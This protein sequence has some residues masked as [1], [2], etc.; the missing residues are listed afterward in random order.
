MSR[1]NGYPSGIVWILAILLA[2]AM[3][4]HW[5]AGGLAIILLGGIAVGLAAVLEVA[6]LRRTPD[7]VEGIAATHSTSRW[8]RLLS[9]L[10]AHEL[11]IF[12][13]LGPLF[14]FPRRAFVLLFVLIPLVWLARWRVR[15]RLT[16]RTPLDVPII[17]L[18]GM[19]AVSVL[20]SADLERSFP[21]L[22]GMLWGIAVY[23]A[24]VNWI[25][26]ERQVEWWVLGLTA[27]GAGVA[28]AAFFGTQWSVS[29]KLLP[30][31]VY[32]WLPRVV[33][34]VP[35]TIQGLI[36]PN[37]AGGSLAFVVPFLFVVMVM[38][39]NEKR[40]TGNRNWLAR[41]CAWFT[42]RGLVIPLAVTVGVLV[43]TQSRSALFGVAVSLLVFCAVRWR[44]FRWVLAMSIVIFLAL[45]IFQGP[46][47]VEPI[48]VGSS[49]QGG[50]AGNLDLAGRQ[51]VWSRALYAMRDFPFT[52]LGLNMFDPVLKLFY[53]LLLAGPDVV[54][55]HAHNNV[56]Q[57]AMD[58]GIPGSVAYLALL[59]AFGY[60]VWFV[61][62]TSPV[63]LSRAVA[64]ALGLGM[65]AHQIFGLTDAVGLGSKPG[66]IFWGMLAAAGGLWVLTF[67]NL[68]PVHA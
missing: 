54:I 50:V 8:Q 65:M 39:W 37:E 11:W 33:A 46:A 47:L 49:G 17:L 19:L 28:I 32:D 30:S 16:P 4:R 9:W 38:Q 55:Q 5:E 45:L 3:F 59:T 60:V 48:L 14:L 58:L 44:L 56:L 26:S 12:L 41:L 68:A 64:L 20:V 6:T 1:L 36:N 34:N 27:L 53:P 62:A 66:I 13:L 52:G 57:V 18:M 43:L 42:G 51:E 10:V 2:S 63:P 15:G 24:I 23:Y 40:N 25:R 67:H 22:A 35:G 29:G 61:F 7:D 21:K 31:Q